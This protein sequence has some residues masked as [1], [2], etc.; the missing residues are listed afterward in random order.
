ML[1]KLRD[2][3]HCTRNICLVA[4][5]PLQALI[6][7]GATETPT[8]PG[9]CCEFRVTGRLRRSHCHADEGRGRHHHRGRAVKLGAQSQGAFW[10]HRHEEMYG[11]LSWDQGLVVGVCWKWTLVMTPIRHSSRRIKIIQRPSTWESHVSMSPPTPITRGFRSW[12]KALPM[13]R[14]IHVLTAAAAPYR[15]GIRTPGRAGTERTTGLM[16]P[17]LWLGIIAFA[18]L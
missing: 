13:G 4:E 1:G 17:C 6:Q 18:I 9:R 14:R 2:G 3:N 15:R 12:P 8:C 7:E 11:R 10:R 5:T 16:S